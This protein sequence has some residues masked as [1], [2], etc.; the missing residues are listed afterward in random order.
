MRDLGQVQE[1]KIMTKTAEVAG[2]RV[3][4]P[5]E[6][7]QE[8]PQK[9]ETDT[10]VTRANGTVQELEEEAGTTHQLRGKALGNPP[11]TAMGQSN[12]LHPRP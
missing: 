10:V 12:N 2:A 3:I 9:A 8:G 4:S 6:T 5:N 1:V 11:V 7:A